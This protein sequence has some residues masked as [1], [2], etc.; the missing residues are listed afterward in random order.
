[1][2][3]REVWRLDIYFVILMSAVEES[4]RTGYI[5]LCAVERTP[6]DQRMVCSVPCLRLLVVLFRSKA[7]PMPKGR[8]ARGSA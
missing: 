6:T 7:K 2:T 8:E 5:S 4:P 1:M 3:K